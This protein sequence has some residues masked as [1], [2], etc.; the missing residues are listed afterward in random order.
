MADFYGYRTSFLEDGERQDPPALK[1]P[2]STHSDTN[3]G[4][5]RG[6]TTTEAVEEQQGLCRAF[7]G[8]GA[9]Q[10]PVSAWLIQEL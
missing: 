6:G 3:C 4:L 8:E 10:P 9:R 5:W 1:T 7:A 2:G